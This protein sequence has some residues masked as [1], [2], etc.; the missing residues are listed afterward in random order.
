MRMQ[1]LTCALGAI[2][3]PWTVSEYGI[4]CQKIIYPER[5]LIAHEYFFAALKRLGH[6]MAHSSLIAAQ[7]LFLTG[8]FY[9]YIH[10]PVAG[11]RLFNS[12][13]I[14][15]R[16]CISKRIA[17]RSNTGRGPWS[18]SEEQRLFWSSFKAER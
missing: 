6:L 4:F 1:F 7:C 14:A 2:S 8:C 12:A 5:I 11:W 9:M 10:K 15:C 3:S 18:R 13:S 17:R 16:G